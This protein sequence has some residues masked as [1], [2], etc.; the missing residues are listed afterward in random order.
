M[1]VKKYSVVLSKPLRKNLISL[2]CPFAKELGNGLRQTY[3]VAK[4]RDAE[5]SR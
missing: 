3:K 4:I 2:M 1:D 5:A